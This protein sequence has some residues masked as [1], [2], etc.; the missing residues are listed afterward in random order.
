MAVILCPSTTLSETPR[1]DQRRFHVDDDDFKPQASAFS[2]PLSALRRQALPFC[3]GICT[4]S[5][6]ATIRTRQAL[7]KPWNWKHTS[8]NHNRTLR[9]SS[10]G[11]RSPIHT[12]CISTTVTA[13][14]L[15]AALK[16]SPDPMIERTADPI[17]IDK[18]ENQD[19]AIHCRPLTMLYLALVET[20]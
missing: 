1:K 14:F 6:S 9:V 11:N 15:G 2:L 4:G 10:V 12:E 17:Q 5:L 19:A 13:K 8:D 20:A 7:R 16:L 3:R 18:P